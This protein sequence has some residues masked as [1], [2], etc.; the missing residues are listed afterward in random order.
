M[1]I[2]GPD[3]ESVPGAADVIDSIIAPLANDIDRIGVPRSSLDALADAGMLGT[4]LPAVQQRELGELIAMADASTWFCWVQHQSPLRGLE[5]A[6]QATVLRARWLDG[7]RAG[8]MLGAVA[9]AHV[10]RPG[11]PNPVARR[12]DGGWLLDGTLDWVTSWDIADVV[13]LLVRDLDTE[14]YV[15]CYLP[16]GRSVECRPGLAV[17]EPLRLLAMSGT[18][19]RPIALDSVFIADDEVAA[20][21]DGATWRRSD[22]IRT[23]D[24]NPAA[25]GLVRGAVAELAAL[26]LPGLDGTVSSLVD[27]CRSLRAAAYALAD[28]ADEANGAE[29]LR[30]RVASLDLAVRATTAVVVARSG[31]AMRAGAAAERRVR[32]AMFLLV[33]AQTAESRAASLGLLSRGR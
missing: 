31:G 11:P 17:G 13:M 30:L 12:V 18:H 7:L 9:F 1:D 2:I 4:P 10:R 26:R 33:Q 22:A 19:T 20:I 25:F 28:V 8:R 29:R 16:A 14:T 3:R 21:I 5:D 23:K 32:E 24:A 6:E 27:E 15:C